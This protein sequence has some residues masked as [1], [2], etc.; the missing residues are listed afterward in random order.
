MWLTELKAPVL[1]PLW[2]VGQEVRAELPSKA[3]SRHFSSQNISVKPHCHSLQSVWTVCVCGGGGG[4]VGGCACIFSI[5]MLEP[6]SITSSFSFFFFFFFFGGGGGGGY[7]ILHL[8]VRYVCMLVQRF[9]PQ[10]R[11]FTNF[12]YYYYY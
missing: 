11:R 8:D 12:H 1:L 5:V 6:L 2:I 10:G 7:N 4:G 9:E 3:N